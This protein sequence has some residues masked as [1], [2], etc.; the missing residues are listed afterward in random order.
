MVDPTQGTL[1]S[2]PAGCLADGTYDF[3][4]RS[5]AMGAYEGARIYAAA[6]ENEQLPQGTRRH[7]VQSGAT[8]LGGSFAI[9]CPHALREN[10]AY[11]SF[12]MF[13]DVDR[14]GHCT[15]ADLGWGGVQ[16][17]GWNAPIDDVIESPS[18]VAASKLAPSIGGAPG[19]TFCSDYFPDPL[20]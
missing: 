20:P 17:Y 3:R 1:V 14:D 13:I 19:S 12:A 2:A 7:P 16:A 4:V 18:F 5:D 6:V 11:P 8:I 10:Y 15:G 9:S